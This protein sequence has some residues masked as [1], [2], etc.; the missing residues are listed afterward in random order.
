[1]TSFHPKLYVTQG[2]HMILN[3][4]LVITQY[5]TAILQLSE[6]AT[7]SNKFILSQYCSNILSYY[8]D[9]AKHANLPESLLFLRD[10]KSV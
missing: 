10:T 5:I 9:I 1:M 6:Y 4:A 2:D 7:S 8:F 3:S